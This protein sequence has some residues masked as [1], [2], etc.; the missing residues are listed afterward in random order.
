ML[1]RFESVSRVVLLGDILDLTRAPRTDAWNEA[2]SFFQE[3]FTEEVF[4]SRPPEICYVPGNHDHHIWMMLVE[5]R[6]IIT[7][8]EASLG[9]SGFATDFPFDVLELNTAPGEFGPSEAS[10]FH[11]VFPKHIQK[12]VRV[13]YPFVQANCQGRNILFHH[14]HYFDRLITPMASRIAGTYIGDIRKVEDCNALFL[15]GIYHLACCGR[16]AREFTLGLYWH[17]GQVLKEYTAVRNKLGLKPGRMPG[18]RIGGIPVRHI[19]DIVR[20]LFEMDSYTLVFGHTHHAD[21]F[22]DEQTSIEIYNTGGWIVDEQDDRVSPGVLD[23]Q[24]GTCTWVECE[25][26]PGEIKAAKGRA[27][28]VRPVGRLERLRRRL[29][30]ILSRVGL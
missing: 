2:I 26:E 6:D 28:A 10:F 5:R 24:D 7:P 8:L 19:T 11:A 18:E 4:P 27:T 23:I 17:Y 20:D 30:S 16:L 12:K 1:A 25:V 9:N 13:C 21:T 14:G 3:I 22:H 15:E 29:A